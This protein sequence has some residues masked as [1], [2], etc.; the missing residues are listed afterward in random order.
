[1]MMLHLLS[2]ASRT[3]R[4]S[5]KQVLNQRRPSHDTDT[6]RSESTTSLQISDPVK[7]LASVS[8]R[9][10]RQKKTRLFDVLIDPMRRRLKTTVREKRLVRKRRRQ[11]KTCVAF[12]LLKAR[13]LMESLIHITTTVNLFMCRDGFKLFIII[14]F[15]S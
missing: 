3:E 6:T 4:I 9:R 5:F 11:A 13:R 10:R 12:V 2:K 15:I 1:M 7:D 14:T 8:P